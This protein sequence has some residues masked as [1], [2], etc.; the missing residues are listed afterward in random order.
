MNNSQL[1]PFRALSPALLRNLQKGGLRFILEFESEHRKSFM[2]EIRDDFLNL[3]FLGHSMEVKGTEKTGFYL[4][5]STTF[6]PEDSLQGTGIKVITNPKTRK[7]QIFFKHIKDV[8]QFR[9]IMDAVMAEIVRHKKGDISEGVSETNHFIEN[10]T[11]SKNGIIVIDRQVVYPGVKDCRIDLLG[12]KKQSNGKF[13]FVV[14]ELKN[15]TNKD[16]KTVFSQV[17]GYID[18]VRDNYEHFKVTYETVVKQKIQLRLLQRFQC[19]IIPSDEGKDMIE[20]IVVLDNYNIRSKLLGLAM[21]DWEK[22]GYLPKVKLFLKSNTFD[23]AFFMDYAK[24]HEFLQKH[25][26]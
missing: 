12:L 5:A 21:P 17:E 20:G 11:N 15:K 3:Y 1:K 22:S 9:L 2:V 8:E 24:A 16:I 23:D 13:K 6:N 26:L 4:S 7:W 10:R 19:E 25:K 18:L 14:I